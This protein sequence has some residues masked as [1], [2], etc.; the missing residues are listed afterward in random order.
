[1]ISRLACARK[2]IRD[3]KATLYLLS[4]ETCF[5]IPY[6]MANDHFRKP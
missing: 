4:K 5:F 1:M 6:K 3:C 2:N